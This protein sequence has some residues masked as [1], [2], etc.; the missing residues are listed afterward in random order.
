M[1]IVSS[2]EQDSDNSCYVHIMATGN[3]PTISFIQQKE[4]SIPFDGITD[5]CSFTIIQVLEYFRKQIR[6]LHVH[7]GQKFTITKFLKRI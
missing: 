6:L 7:H 3:L 2:T 4:V 1:A 5:C